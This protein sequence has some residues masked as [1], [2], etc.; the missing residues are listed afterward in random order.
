[1]ALISWIL[2][3][4]LVFANE[5]SSLE[6]FPSTNLEQVKI[7]D[8][9]LDLSES[10]SVEKLVQTRSSNPTPPDAPNFR[11][12]YYQTFSDGVAHRYFNETEESLLNKVRL[13]Q[14][15]GFG[16][17]QPRHL[18]WF[19]TL[20]PNTDVRL[21]GYQQMLDAPTV[22]AKWD[23]QIIG[24]ENRKN[25]LTN[26]NFN[27]AL[28]FSDTSPLVAGDSQYS[29]GLDASQSKNKTLQWLA[30]L[31]LA[32]LEARK[33]SQALNDI[34]KLMEPSSN[35]ITA[36]PI[37]QEVIS[38][39]LYAEGTSKAALKIMDKVD[40][41]KHLDDFGDLFDDIYRGFLDSKIPEKK[42][43][44]MTWKVLAV[45]SAR[46]ANVGK[47]FQYVDNVTSARTLM[48][49][50]TIAMG[51]SVLDTVSTQKG[52]LYSLPKNI[53]TVAPYAKTYHF[54]M[55][56]FLARE[57]SLKYGSEKVGKA[58]ASLVSLAY[59]MLS[60]TCGRNELFESVLSE[61]DSINTKK[62]KID[63]AF[64][65]SGASYG[66]K[67]AMGKAHE[68][69][70]NIDKIIQKQIFE[71][72]TVSNWSTEKVKDF[73]NAPIKKYFAFL[74]WV[75]VI[76]PLGIDDSVQSQVGCNRFF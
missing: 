6:E 54:W 17:K 32:P 70:I 27:I 56:A 48:A 64:G 35:N 46:G 10:E 2:F 50:Q 39:P 23:A 4:L 7:V 49:M 22:E 3:S 41:H 58:S 36:L 74:K 1:M 68:V 12:F 28:D 52:F 60:T 15:I 40:H 29:V 30:C 11:E 13:N 20:H 33:C 75:N 16:E 37:I 18:M 38:D 31:R 66:S 47:L 34:I 69:D 24:K 67:S 71:A 55:S 59:Q 9:S 45:I 19:F 25:F 61:P 51:S 57:M 65:F 62:V 53:K 8:E 21:Y 72:K 14:E 44:D 42:A 73:L 5:Q 26:K 63:L 43:A 76:K